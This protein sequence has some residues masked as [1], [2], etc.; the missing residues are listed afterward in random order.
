VIRTKHVF[1]QD[2]ACLRYAALGDTAVR[3]IALK[4]LVDFYQLDAIVVPQPNPALRALWVDVFG[5]ERVV[6]DPAAIPDRFRYA[7]VSHPT[8]L[9]WAYGAAGWNVFESVM[10]ESGFFATRN[11]RITP[12]TVYSCDPEARAAM[13]YPA[14]HTDGNRVYTSDWWNRTC[15]LLRSKGYALHHLGDPAYAPLAGLY[16]NQD[17]DRYFP[18]QFSGLKAC[19]ACSSIAIGGSTGPTWVA[20]LSDIPQVVLDSR[21][22][23]HAY[24]YFDRCQAVLTKRLRVYTELDVLV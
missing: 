18:A 5:P 2:V 11:L 21:R 6:D 20:L 3:V 24:W 13:I 1:R 12:P 19:L 16:A 10:W 15:D 17:F 4:H 9:D 22:A 7:R 14:E 23:P 8:S